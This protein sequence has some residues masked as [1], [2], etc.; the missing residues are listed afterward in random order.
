[1]TGGDGPGCPWTPVLGGWFL[2]RSCQKSLTGCAQW[3]RLRQG[4][5]TRGLGSVPTKGCEGSSRGTDDRDQP[6]TQ[7]LDGETGGPPLN[8]CLGLKSGGWGAVGT[9]G[10]SAHAS[11]DSG[12]AGSRVQG[13]SHLLGPRGL[14]QGAVPARHRALLGGPGAGSLGLLPAV[15]RGPSSHPCP[16]CS[17]GCHQGPSPPTQ[18]H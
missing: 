17:R 15:P 1:M 6:F 5:R 3:T 4:L 13:S 8:T 12:N 14:S 18:K 11:Q 10:G 7:A 16:L 9:P 2:L